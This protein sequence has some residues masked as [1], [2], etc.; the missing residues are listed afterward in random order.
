MIENPYNWY[1][2]CVDY[3]IT[4]KTS[5]DYGLLFLIDESAPENVKTS[6][7]KYLDICI[8][9]FISRGLHFVKDNHIAGFLETNNPIEQEQIRLFKYLVHQGIIDNSV[10]SPKII[11]LNR[12]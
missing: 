1:L 7:L 11:G 10:F 9:P 2:E 3:A 5:M 8:N 6:Y 12:P 4:N